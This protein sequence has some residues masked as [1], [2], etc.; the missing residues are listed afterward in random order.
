M[1][2]L[3]S[4]LV[5]IFNTNFSFHPFE[6]ILVLPLKVKTRSNKICRNKI[7]KNGKPTADQYVRN[8]WYK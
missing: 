8:S 6:I 5:F 3:S 2:Y 7:P 1:K 4:F